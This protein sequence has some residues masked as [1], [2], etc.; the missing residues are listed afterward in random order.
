[1]SFS[2]CD[3]P[4]AR[5]AVADAGHSDATAVR[6]KPARYGPAQPGGGGGRQR[7][8]LFCQPGRHRGGIEIRAFR[9]GQEFPGTLDA[10][11]PGR[12]DVELRATGP[13]DITGPRCRH[14]KRAPRH[15]AATRECAGIAAMNPVAATSSP[16]ESPPP[17]DAGWSP[18]Q[19]FAVILLA[20][21][22]HLGFI[23]T[24]GELKPAAPRAVMNVPALR[25]AAP[26]DE[27]MALNDP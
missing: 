21:T 12:R 27:L 24:F 25:L 2:S 18:A 9:G 17:P 7:T 3:V 10:G 4:V 5:H 20:L 19:W 16:P 14:P 1:G 11:H 13:S 23:M 6:R 22:A 8:A 15:A 26:T